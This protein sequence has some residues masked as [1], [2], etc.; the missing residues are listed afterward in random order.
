MSTKKTN[1]L[2]SYGFIMEVIGNPRG[3]VK[4][5]VR[6]IDDDDF[7]TGN[8]LAMVSM[9]SETKLKYLTKY[10]DVKL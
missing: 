4:V 10:E 3:K 2:I 8:A 9:E 6:R 7:L 5:K 1:S